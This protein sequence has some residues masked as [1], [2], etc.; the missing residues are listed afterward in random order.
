MS[1]SG[2]VLGKI[3]VVIGRDRKEDDWYLLYSETFATG[4]DLSRDDNGSVGSTVQYMGECIQ[5]HHEFDGYV[6]EDTG[7]FEIVGDLF[8]WGEEIWTD[9][10]Y[11]HDAGEEIQ[12]HESHQMSD[13]EIDNF[14]QHF[15]EEWLEYQ[16]ESVGVEPG[17]GDKKLPPLEFR[18]VHPIDI[19]VEANNGGDFFELMQTNVMKTKGQVHVKVGHCCV[20]MFDGLVPVEFLTCMFSYMNEH[21]IGAKE[22][23]SQWDT[24]VR[25]KLLEKVDIDRG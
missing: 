14:K 18:M 21:E 17:E 19:H 9:C 4:F 8:A 24:D 20:Y 25:N 2:S 10:G 16:Q 1:R 22:L 3:R 7:I 15:P 12:N 6:E 23:F 11:E 5:E 13:K